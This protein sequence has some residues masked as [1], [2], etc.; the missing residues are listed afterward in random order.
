MSLNLLKKVSAQN[1][2]SGVLIRDTK[3]VNDDGISTLYNY[4]WKL[5]ADIDFNIDDDEQSERFMDKDWETET[6]FPTPF[7]EAE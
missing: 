7:S 1:N 5:T 4:W 2:N 3:K 6:I